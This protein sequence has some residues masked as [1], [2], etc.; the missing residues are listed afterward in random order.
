MP[1]R[2]FFLYARILCSEPGARNAWSDTHDLY[3][4]DEDGA[5]RVLLAKD[6]LRN[7]FFFTPDGSRIFFENDLFD[8]TKRTF[9]SVAIDGS[10]FHQISFL[11]FIVAM[12]QLSPD[13]RHFVYGSL[14]AIYILDAATRKLRHN[15]QLANC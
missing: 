12:D 14:E 3:A 2:L 6:I 9:A 7:E 15:I 8:P 5:N 10:D 1:R 11:E 13:G 4:M